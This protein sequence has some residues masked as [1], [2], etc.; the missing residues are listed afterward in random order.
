M[1]EGRGMVEGTLL[2]DGTIIWINGCNRGAQGF[3]IATDPTLDVLIYNPE[4]ALGN[5]W[6]IGPRST[7]ARLYHSVALLLLDGT[8]L[9]AGSNPVQMPVLNADAENPFPTEFRME[10][11]TPPYLSRDN[12]RKRP[13]DVKLSS[14]TFKADATK[15]TIKFKSF[16]TSTKVEV[17]LYFGGFVTHSLHMGH[18]MIFLDNTG[19]AKGKTKQT[20]YVTMP[21]DGNI[22]P[23]GPYVLYVMLDGVPSV[24]QFIMVS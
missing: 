11:Y 24:G 10:V 16:K 1:P 3:E 23:P 12:A 4:Q 8:L 6:S 2:P 5:R 19:F 17:T 20:L 14:K 18:R 13:T 7:I 15:F 21:P 9:I 22:A